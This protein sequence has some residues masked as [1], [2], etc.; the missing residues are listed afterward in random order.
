LILCSNDHTIKSTK[1]ILNNKFNIKNLGVVDVIIEIKII[2]TSNGLILFQ[3]Y[4]VE[5]I[6]NKFS[7]DDHSLIKA[8][9]YLIVHPSISKCKRIDQLEY[10]CIIRSLIYFINCTRLDIAYSINNFSRFTNNS[11]MYNWKAIKKGTQIF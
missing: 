8:P 11:N 9:I 6:L 5:K 1:K 2:K 3:S 4:Y 10:F 7:I